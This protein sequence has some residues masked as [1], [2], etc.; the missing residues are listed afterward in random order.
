MEYLG[1]TIQVVKD[2]L[3]FNFQEYMT[4]ENYGDV[5]HIDHTLP[6]NLFDLTQDID[7]Y[8]CF[9]WKNLMPL[10]KDINTKKH[11]HIWPI[12][13]FN[14]EQRLLQFTKAFEIEKSEIDDYLETYCEY[15]KSMMAKKS[16]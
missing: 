1:S 10:R 7:I 12:R 14:Q 11:D 4:W 15:F 16:K 6:V 13:V 3:Q 8:M 2:W 9:N 5:W